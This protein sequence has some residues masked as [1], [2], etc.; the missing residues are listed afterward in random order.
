[1][2]NVKLAPPPPAPHRA[3]KKL[4]VAYRFPRPLIEALDAYADAQNVSRN[5]ALEHLLSWALSAAGYDPK[6]A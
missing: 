3:E 2:A 6:A 1:M 5:G 4:P